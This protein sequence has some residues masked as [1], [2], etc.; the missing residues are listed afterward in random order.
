MNSS[1]FLRSP[2]TQWKLPVPKFSAPEMHTLRLVPGVRRGFCF[3]LRIQ[4]KPTLGLDSSLVSSWKNDPALFTIERM[5]SSLSRAEPHEA[6]SSGT[7][8]G[9]V[10]GESSPGLPPQTAP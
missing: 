3:P 7:Q 9:E 4:Q 8:G 10:R 1:S 5:S 6:S 2:V